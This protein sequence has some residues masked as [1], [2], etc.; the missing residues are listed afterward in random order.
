MATFVLVHG[1]WNGAH[2]FRHIPAVSSPASGHVVFTPSLTGDRRA[3]PPDE[4]ASE[5]LHARRRRHQRRSS[6]RSWSTSS[7]SGSPT[8]GSSSPGAWNMW[9]IAS[10]HLVY[11]DAFVPDDGDSVERLAGRDGDQRIRPSATAGWSPG[12]PA[13]Y[14]DRAEEA[15]MA[16]PAQRASPSVLHRTGPA[17]RSTRGVPVL[18]DVHPGH[19]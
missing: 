12:R 10:P 1:A 16:A 3:S 18:A 19:R 2:G 13:R 11:L 7:W 9:P 8:A 6:T 14:D 15:F 4:P 5:P 17:A